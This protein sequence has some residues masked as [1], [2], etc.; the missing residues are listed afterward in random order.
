MYTG[1]TVTFLTIGI[2]IS[3]NV[4]DASEFDNPSAVIEN[5]VGFDVVIPS[6]AVNVIVMFSRGFVPPEESW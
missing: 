4:T 5:S 3:S 2:V 1:S 6:F